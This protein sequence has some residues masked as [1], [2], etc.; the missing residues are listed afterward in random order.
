CGPHPSRLDV[1]PVTSSR[2]VACSK[3][4]RRQQRS[5]PSLS[6]WGATP[7]TPSLASSPPTQQGSNSGR[8]DTCDEHAAAESHCCRHEQ[9][10]LDAGRKKKNKHPIKRFGTTRKNR[11]RHTRRSAVKQA[12]KPKLLQQIHREAKEKIH[13]N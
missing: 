13:T 7:P 4:C 5:V 9:T 12:P 3:D 11:N 2:Q 8:C 10:R 1:T 6:H